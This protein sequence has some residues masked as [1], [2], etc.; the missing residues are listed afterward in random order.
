MKLMLSS[1]CFLLAGLLSFVPLYAQDRLLKG[2]VQDGTSHLPITGVYVSCKENHANVITDSS[3]RFTLKITN[4]LCTLV[5]KSMGY[6]TKQMTV[7][8]LDNDLVIP[9][10]ADVQEMR[11]VVVTGYTQ[12]SRNKTTGAVSTIKAAAIDNNPVGSF[13]VMLQGRAPGLYVGTPTG[14]PGEAGRV[15]IRG[16]GSINGDTNPLYIVDGVP[17]AAAS[18]AALNTDDFESINVLKDAASTAPYGSRA[19][20]GVVVITTKKGMALP[21]GKVR[22][23]YK[24]QMG[25]SEVNSSKW[26]MM[27]TSQRLQFEEILQDP[28]LPGWA[29]SANNPNKIVNG[30]STP[31]T[32]ADYAFGKHYLD[33]LKTI[34]TDWRKY[35]LR[36]AFTQSHTLNLSGGNDRTLFYIA[37]SYLNQE[38][39]ALNSSLKR[40]SL[41]ANIQNTSGRLK[42]SL[43][44][45]LSTAAVRYIQDEGVAPQGGAAVGGGGITEKN[46]I[47][48]LYYA[49]PYQSPTDSAGPG[50]FGSNALDVYRNSLRK[51]NQIKAV[52]SLNED[53]RLSSNLHL[54]GTVGIDYQQSNFTNYLNPDSYY[55][56]QEPNGNRGSYQRSL[57]TRLGLIAN[58]GI[59]YNKKWGDHEL[60]ANLLAEMNRIK[61]EGFGFTG[62]GLN[63][64]LLNTPAGVSQGTAD[65]NFIPAISGQTTPDN[66]LL[67]QIAIARYSYSNKYT[68]SASLR[69]D[70]SSQVPA[71]NRYKY[72]YAVGGSW[73]VLSESFA[74][75]L[76]THFSYLRLRASYGLTGNAGGFASDYGYR[77]LYAPANYA[78]QSA[79]ELQTPG[80]PAYNWEMNRIADVAVEA[81]FFKN[82]LRTELDFYNRITDGLFVNRNLSLTTGFATISSNEGRI[83]NRGVELMIEGD[84]IKQKD[85]K[86]TAG[87]NLAY[88]QNMVLTL[89]NERKIF[90]DEASMSLPG[91]ALGTFY[92]VRWQGVD[93]A[94]GA[95]IYLTKDGKTTNTYNSG[96]AVPM[97]GK[98]YDPPY[99]GGF[100]L[101][102]T[103]K[104]FEVSLLMSFIKGMS[105]LNYPNLY[106]HSGD[107]NYRQYNQ[108]ADMLNIWQ[109]PGDHVAYAGAQYPTFFTSRDI[110]SADYLKLRNLS[111]AYHVPL[112]TNL[113]KYI[114]GLKVFA[115]GQNLFSFMKWRGFDPEDANDIAQYEYPMPRMITGGI[116][117][118]F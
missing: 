101:N 72:F 24:T 29:Y 39:I 17:I 58:G 56:A 59:R 8:P 57:A 32:A 50:N 48:S 98:V 73:N 4:Q 12:Q 71:L 86:V 110:M 65:N 84:I 108:S 113:S 61:G 46:P 90:A 27:N 104:Q 81:G 5:I 69:R 3:G 112:G 14:Q 114:H 49:L 18:F 22:I 55:G 76:R 74:E 82:R 53:F 51:D 43:S 102:V 36:K 7:T 66:L 40:Y 97:A 33:S 89:G 75:R 20:N 85:W 44:V 111:I 42:S 37:A 96:D 109:K 68:L 16:L 25:F 6:E 41:R 13:D 83:R 60:E 10:T 11:E 78:G 106:A 91:Y 54:I 95:P 64:L 9:L 107:A 26:D 79:Y 115:Y 45:G 62:Y 80:N 19:A 94:T 34:N 31:K 100:T 21:D 92:A 28:N 2:R 88:N 103:Y 35:L 118:S 63:S 15:T 23:N 52:V 38:G 99:K 30:V 117:V 105:R 47:A 116:N 67:S 1:I 77:E 93:P 70:G 87:L